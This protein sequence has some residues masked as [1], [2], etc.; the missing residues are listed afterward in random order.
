VHGLR[1]P[2]HVILRPIFFMEN[3]FT[4]FSLQGFRTGLGSRPDGNARRRDAAN[5]S[6]GQQSVRGLLLHEEWQDRAIRLLSRA[7]YH[8]QANGRAA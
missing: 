2:S 6:K 7:Q 4:P 3:L 8:A 1:F 5:R